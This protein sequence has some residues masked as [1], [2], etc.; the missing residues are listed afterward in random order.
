[1]LYGGSSTNVYRYLPF[2]LEIM[3]IY[4]VL[5]LVRFDDKRTNIFSWNIKRKCSRCPIGSKNI[6]KK[7]MY[8]W[9]WILKITL[10]K[11]YE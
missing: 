5:F 1:M 2:Y 6:N 8:S 3:D 7:R 11:Q 10:A 4:R 9:V